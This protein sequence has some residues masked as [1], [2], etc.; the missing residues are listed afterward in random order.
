[1]PHSGRISIGRKRDQLPV[2]AVRLRGRSPCF[3]P[4]HGGNRRWRAMPSTG[5]EA[6]SYQFEDGSP[7]LRDHLQPCHLPIYREINTSETDARKKDV[8]AITQGLV[9]Q[10]VNGGR[11][12]FRAVR[13]SP[14]SIYFGVSFVDSHLQWCMGHRK[15]NELLPV[16]W[17][18]QAT[19]FFQ[20]LIEGSCGQRR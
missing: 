8:D 12:R 4:R 19:G 17:P 9:V 20:P 13:L 18:R 5:F 3:H 1:M 16:S 7:I 6:F 11:K 10:R 15:W 2:V 14:T